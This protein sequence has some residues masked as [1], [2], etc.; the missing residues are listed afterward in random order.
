MKKFLLSLILGFILVSCGQD[1]LGTQIGDSMQKAVDDTTDELHDF[2]IK[3]NDV[4]QDAVEDYE[5]ERDRFL[6][7][8][9]ADTGALNRYSIEAKDNIADEGGRFSETVKNQG[10]RSNEEL[11][12]TLHKTNADFNDQKA[13]L[14]D[15]LVGDDGDKH[16][17]LDAKNIEQDNRLN[18]LEALGELHSNILNTFEVDLFS[19]NKD[20]LTLQSQLLDIQNVFIPYVNGAIDRIDATLDD[21]DTD[22]NQVASDL[23]DLSDAVDLLPTEDTD[24]KCSVTKTGP[25]WNRQVTITCP[26]QAPV[27]F[28]VLP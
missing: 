10:K 24:T 2:N 20:I 6:D 11:N 27:S 17:E 1:E 21:Q 12:D 7:A 14:T 5:G 25:W 28:S 16:A 9:E 15:S 3:V 26:D 23:T 13:K 22:I 18:A 8:R 4:K 19:I